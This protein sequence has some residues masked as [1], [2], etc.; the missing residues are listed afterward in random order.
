MSE[1]IRI[2][3]LLSVALNSGL[4]VCSFLIAEYEEYEEQNYA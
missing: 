4:L 1:V 2:L 3:L